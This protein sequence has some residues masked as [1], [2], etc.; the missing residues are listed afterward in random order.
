MNDN[1][2]ESG[3][4]QRAWYRF[5]RLCLFSTGRLNQRSITAQNVLA[6]WRHARDGACAEAPGR[7]WSASVWAPSQLKQNTIVQYIQ[8][9]EGKWQK[10]QKKKLTVLFK[11]MAH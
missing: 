8:F 4:E 2:N 6:S 3:E 11:L 1:R 7:H 9:K 10:S 5:L